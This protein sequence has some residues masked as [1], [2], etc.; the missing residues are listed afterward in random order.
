MSSTGEVFQCR[1]GNITPRKATFQRLA[2]FFRYLL[3][4]LSAKPMFDKKKKKKKKFF[5][6]FYSYFSFYARERNLEPFLL[7]K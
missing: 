5:K 1:G 6:K 2:K 4:P 3:N 7:A